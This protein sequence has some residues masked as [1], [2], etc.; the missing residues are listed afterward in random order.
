M[1]AY[2]I[3]N[4]RFALISAGTI[5]RRRFVTVDNTG[6]AVQASAAG[7]AIG[8]SSVPSTVGKIVE[9][10]DGIVIVEAGAAIVPGVRVEADASARAITLAAGIPLGT[11]LTSAAAAGEFVA[12]KTTN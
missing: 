2:E 8:A 6:Q 4:L 5:A 3:P 12:V 11:A 1:A 7:N 10:Y 9:V